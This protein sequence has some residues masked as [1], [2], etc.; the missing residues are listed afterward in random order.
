PPVC[1]LCISSNNSQAHSPRYICLPRS[2]HPPGHIPPHRHSNIATMPPSKRSAS[3]FGIPAAKRVRREEASNEHQPSNEEV[4]DC[5]VVA[6]P[7]AKPSLSTRHEAVERSVAGPTASSVSSTKFNPVNPVPIHVQAQHVQ[8][9]VQHHNQQQPLQ[10][11]HAPASHQPSPHHLLRQQAHEGS[12]SDTVQTAA[13]KVT[14][15]KPYKYTY[16]SEDSLVYRCSGLSRE[17]LRSHVDTT[18]ANYLGGQ[19]SHV[20]LWP[21]NDDRTGIIGN[22]PGRYFV[23]VPS[24]RKADIGKAIADIIIDGL[25]VS[26]EGPY[27]F[28]PGIVEEMTYCLS[29]QDRDAERVMDNV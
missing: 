6:A 21:K 17:T 18:F 16:D 13:T 15:S 23:A 4:R 26:I 27:K 28:P 22:N 19:D 3:D 24:K 12:E 5:I 7:E 8:Q 20:V 9:H 25:R 29:E 14:S 2:L 10:L 1:S 11:S